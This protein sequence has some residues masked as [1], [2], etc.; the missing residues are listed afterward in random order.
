MWTYN[1]TPSSDDIIH[2]GVL[3]IRWGHRKAIIPSV[4]QVSTN[5]AVNKATDA[6]AKMQSAKKA[7]KT[8]NKKFDKAYRNSNSWILNSQFDKKDNKRRKDEMMKA[9]QKAEAAQ[10]AYKKAKANY[11]LSDKRA[12]SMVKDIKKQYRKQYMAGE[13]FIG[14]MYGKVSGSDRTYAD[15]QYEFNRNHK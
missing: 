13:S 9:A 15:L 5:R 7:Y 1:Y 10:K 14:K 3:G 8:A 6:K 2:Y 11:K 12:K 4:S